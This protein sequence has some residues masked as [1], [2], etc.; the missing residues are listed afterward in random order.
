MEIGNEASVINPYEHGLH[1]R[2]GTVME[3]PTNNTETV[4]AGRWTVVLAWS[5]MGEQLWDFFVPFPKGSCGFTNALLITLYFV[6]Q[7]L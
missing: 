3:L 5:K 2:S 7:K 4:H 6:T 1:D